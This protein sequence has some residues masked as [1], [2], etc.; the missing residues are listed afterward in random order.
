MREVVGGVL[1]SRPLAVGIHIRRGDL[2][3]GFTHR[4]LPASYFLRVM[5]LLESGSFLA[6]S[7]FPF[8]LP[9]NS[10]PIQFHSGARA[11][12]NPLDDGRSQSAY[13]PRARRWPCRAPSSSSRSLRNKLC[14]SRRSTPS[15][16]LGSNLRR[17][18]NL[19]FIPTHPNPPQPHPVPPHVSQ[20]QPAFTFTPL[21]YTP[22]T[23]P[24][25]SPNP[26]S[27]SPLS[28]TPHPHRPNPTP[29]PNVTFRWRSQQMKTHSPSSTAS[30]I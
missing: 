12:S 23:P 26:P 24:Q 16:D 20:P 25:P 28:N 21:N 6:A 29:H 19:N 9:P 3:V 4:L 10:D 7:C 27:P 18:A 15:S 2:F 17:A 22:P 5:P 8:S 13:W 1:A 14:A 30:Q 11:L